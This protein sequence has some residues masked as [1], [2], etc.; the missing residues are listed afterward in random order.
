MRIPSPLILTALL[1]AGLSVGCGKKEE[2][3]PLP[4]PGPLQP[5]AVRSGP[6]LRT[7]ADAPV[8]GQYPPGVRPGAGGGPPR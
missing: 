3:M 1:L 4:S 8:P 2:P 6:A 7:P 5:G